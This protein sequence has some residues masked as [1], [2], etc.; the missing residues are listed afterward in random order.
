MTYYYSFLFYS[1]EHKYNKTV[2]L[3]LFKHIAKNIAYENTDESTGTKVI[4]S[5][6]LQDKVDSIDKE[7]DNVGYLGDIAS[8]N[9][10]NYDISV[11]EDE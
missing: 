4:T 7:F 6:S 2:Q 5:I 1:T 3:R 11:Q 8:I 9:Y 10:I